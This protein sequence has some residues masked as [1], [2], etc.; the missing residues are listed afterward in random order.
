MLLQLLGQFF[1]DPQHPGLQPEGNVLVVEVEGVRLACHRGQV[2]EV[3]VAESFDKM[4]HLLDSLFF[5][6]VAVG[7]FL[8]DQQ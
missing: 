6:F 2:D 7:Q 4:D 3:W 8:V 5:L 1:V